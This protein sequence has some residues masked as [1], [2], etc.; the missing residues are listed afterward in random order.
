MVKIIF[1]LLAFILCIGATT[2]RAGW[3]Y[4]GSNTFTIKEDA[5]IR[6]YHDP[7]RSQPYENLEGEHAMYE[8]RLKAGK[9]VLTIEGYYFM[10]LE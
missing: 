4:S 1:S 7:S 5:T 10:E 6:L 2:Q 3:S 8:K 9:Y